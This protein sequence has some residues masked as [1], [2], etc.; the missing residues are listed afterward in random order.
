MTDQNPRP[1]SSDKNKLIITKIIVIYSAFFLIL[2]LSAIFQGGWVMANLLVAL[3]LVV[4]G[5][6]GFYF[7]KSNSTNWIYALGS[8]VIISAMRYYEQDLIVWIH[9]T[10]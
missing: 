9:N 7:L 1:F 5:L 6:L 8:I 10:I 3:P 4:L 2:K